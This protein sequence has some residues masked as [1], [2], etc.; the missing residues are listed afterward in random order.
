MNCHRAGREKPLNERESFAFVGPNSQNQT[1]AQW[2]EFEFYT[3]KVEL[4]FILQ[5]MHVEIYERTYQFPTLLGEALS[6]FPGAE[7][8]R[9]VHVVQMGGFANASFVYFDDFT[10]EF[11]VIFSHRTVHRSRCRIPNR[12]IWVV[13]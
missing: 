3:I 2:D 9:E 10:S 12:K 4:D 13:C 7:H 1:I 5:S 6:G 8:I 11:C